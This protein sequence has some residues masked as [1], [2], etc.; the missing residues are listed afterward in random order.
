M[1]NTSRLLMFACSFL[2]IAGGVAL[3]EDKCSDFLIQFTEPDDGSQLQNQVQQRQITALV[4]CDEPQPA[5][6]ASIPT[7]LHIFERRENQFCVAQRTCGNIRAWHGS[8]AVYAGWSDLTL[9][10]DFHLLGNSIRYH[11]DW[12][13]NR[14]VASFAL[15]G[16]QIERDCSPLTPPSCVSVEK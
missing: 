11:R 5:G 16:G 9:L 1:T 15:S 13:G 10:G 6:S 7:T 12:N 4:P 2:N 3:A 14:I 8:F